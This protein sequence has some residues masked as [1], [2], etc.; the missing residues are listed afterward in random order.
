MSSQQTIASIDNWIN[1]L[2]PLLISRG[3]TL[4][5]K[6]G[7]KAGKLSATRNWCQIVDEGTSL[8]ISFPNS[9]DQM[10]T[11]KL[12]ARFGIE[13]TPSSHW[14][15][16]KGSDKKVVRRVISG[17]DVWGL[18][19]EDIEKWTRTTNDKQILE[20][21]VRDLQKS[22]NYSRQRYC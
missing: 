20:R 16:L 22:F 6:Q 7:Y 14:E 17:D 9:Q 12:F 10:K 4:K 1:T 2:V 3:I 11:W 5:Q 15:K 21:L 18:S 13:Q 19:Y 8:P